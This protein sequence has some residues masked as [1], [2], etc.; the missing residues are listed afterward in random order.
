MVAAMRDMETGRVVAVHRTR[1]TQDGCKVD[2]KM[3]GPTRGA[4]VMLDPPE[5]VTIG[6]AVGEG[7]ETCL[8][9]RQL[10]LRPAWALGSVGAISALPVLPGIETLTV[11]GEND[12]TG[13]SARACSEVGTRWHRAG[14]LVDIV[15]PRTGSDLN[16]TLRS[17]AWR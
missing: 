8:A 7:V 3:F 13:A 5:A 1:L 11:L 9:A 14:R 16:D 12:T 2:R 17:V 4:A 15:T 10:G 6:L